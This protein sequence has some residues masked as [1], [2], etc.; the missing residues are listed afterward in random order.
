MWNVRLTD[1]E[2]PALAG[3]LS[4][5][6]ARVTDLMRNPDD[7]DEQLP[8]VCLLVIRDE[9]ALLLPDEDFILRHGDELLFAGDAAARRALSTTTLLDA[10]AEYVLYDRHIPSSW[11]W[12]WF[13]HKRALA[14]AGR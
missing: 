4:S 5:G 6:E 9:D 7:R 14:A 1:T 13:T 3:W 12:R 8:A 10:T 11:I 2:T